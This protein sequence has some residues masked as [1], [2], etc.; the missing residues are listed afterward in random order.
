[1]ENPSPS[2]VALLISSAL[3]YSRN[4]LRGIKSYTAPGKNWICHYADPLTTPIEQLIAWRPSGVV[5]AAARPE[6]IDALAK[7][8]VPVVNVSSALAD[9]P[10]VRVMVDNDAIGQIVGR[11]FLDRGFSC[12]GY[13]GLAG[14]EYSVRRHA[15]FS[16][17][18]RAVGKEVSAYQDDSNRS[19]QRRTRSWATLDEKLRDWVSRLGRP[20]AIMPCDDWLGMQLAETCRYAGLRVPEDV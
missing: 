1:M 7:L 3:G 20:C 10:F 19:D 8:D 5:A 18:L 4:V 13:V 11:Y 15:G 16:K 9:S 6:L 14:R 2:R 12:F 17:V